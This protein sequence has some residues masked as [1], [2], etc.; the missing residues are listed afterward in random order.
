MDTN[1]HELGRGVGFVRE[2]L[3]PEFLT[4]EPLNLAL[5]EAELQS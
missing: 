1:G 2:P 4:P 5:T 3:N